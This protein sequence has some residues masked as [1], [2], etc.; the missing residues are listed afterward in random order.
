MNAIWTHTLAAS[1][2]ALAAAGLAWLA[3]N[4]ALVMGRLPAVTAKRL[5]HQPVPLPSGLPS[6]RTLVLVAFSRHHQADLASWMAG[7]GLR[8]GGEL[9][10]VRLPV[11][12]DPGHEQ[13]RAAVE[14]RLKSRYPSADERARVLPVFT[15][16]AAFVR[17]VGLGGTERASV[18]VVNRQGE[19]LAR[20][21]G[22]FDPEKA[23][24]LRATVLG[25]DD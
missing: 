25:L 12:A 1:A 18:L 24:A 10:W 8:Q 19:V 16:P 7:L 3:P 4:D 20:A 13:G 23:A 5:D 6:E 17:T 22:A 21:S 15:D 2:V 9:P 14:D 11:I